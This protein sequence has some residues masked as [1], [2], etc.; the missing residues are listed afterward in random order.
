[1]ARCRY[2][3][4]YIRGGLLLIGAGLAFIG[5]VAAKFRPGGDRAY[6]GNLRIPAPWTRR[7]ARAKQRK[8]APK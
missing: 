8:V 4:R 7:P 5:L 1:M 2:G 3:T 6:T